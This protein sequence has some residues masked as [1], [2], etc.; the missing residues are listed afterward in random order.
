M[1]W[2]AFDRAIK[3]CERFGLDGDLDGWQ[4]TRQE[5]HDDVCRL[6]FDAE[7]GSF[8]QSYGSKQVDASLLLIPLVGFLPPGDPRIAGTVQ[9]MEKCLIRDGLVMRYDTAKVE[10]GLPCGRGSVFG[11]QFLDGG[12]LSPSRPEREGAEAPRAGAETSQ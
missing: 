4:A 10:D 1:A 6:G 8:V 3:T 2:V 11:V 5:I 7:L 12:R 9:Q